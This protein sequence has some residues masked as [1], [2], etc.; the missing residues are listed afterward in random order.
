[1]ISIG[2]TVDDIKRYSRGPDTLIGT[3]YS[4]FQYQHA[5]KVKDYF[6]YMIDYIYSHYIQ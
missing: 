2:I 6:L 1:M 3:D 5:N 4:T